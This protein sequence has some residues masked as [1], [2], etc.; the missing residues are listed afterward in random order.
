MSYKN[1]KS[2]TKKA[3][4]KDERTSIL[5]WILLGLT[6]LFLFWAPFQK[7]LF[8][9][10]TYDFERPLFS[11]FIWSA[12]ILFLVSL[13]QFYNWK[14]SSQRDL[15]SIVIWLIP[16][17]YVISLSSSASS[18]YAQ[19]GIYIQL[20]YV[21]FF[22][23]G[24]YINR[25]ES[26]TNLL[27]RFFVA[28][29][30]FVVLFGLFNWLGNK[31]IIFNMVSWFTNGMDGFGF[32][33]DAVMTDA[34][35]FRLTS[36]FQYANSYAAYLIAILFCCIYL[37]ISSKKL[38]PTLVHGMMAVP[39]IISFFLTLSR[40]GLV[41]LPIVLLVILPFLKPYKQVLYLVH[42]IISFVISL[43]ILNKVTSLGIEVNK[44]SIPNISYL[45]WGIL[46]A[47][48]LINGVI[49]VAIQKCEPFVEKKLSNI[50][51]YRVSNIFIPAVAIIIGALGVLLLL[52][53]TGLTQLLP[54]NIKN[55]IESINFQQHSVLE[56]GTFYVDA[57]KLYKDYP[58]IGAG[59]GA[60]AAL[61]EKYQNNPYVSRQA[62]N[63]FLQYL[64]EVG[65]LGFLI[66]L[67]VIG[68]VLY[69]FIRHSIKSQSAASDD[70]RFM[71]YIV[72]ISLL[73]HSMIDF[74]LSYVYLGALLFLSLGGM[75]S[76]SEQPALSEKW[77]AF[78]KYKW[79]YPSVLVVLS[80][81][82]FFSSTKMLTANSN[83]QSALSLA[84]SS[85]TIN[86][87]F[88]PLDNALKQHPNHPDY[89]SYKIDLLLQAYNQTKDEKLFNQ[90]TDMIQKTR[91]KE[92]HNRA[93]IDKEIYTLAIK[94][95]LPKALELVNNEINNFPWDIT[96]YEKNI[97]M[98]Y[99]LGTRSQSDKALAEKYWSQAMET[100]NTMVNKSKELELLPKGQQQGRPFGLTK[101]M[102]FTLGQI[103]FMHGKYASAESFLKFQLN[104]Q[105]N[106]QV[107]VEMARWYL[108]SLQKQNKNDES[109]YNKLITKDP[110]EKDEI[111]TLLNAT[112]SVK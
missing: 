77:L 76:G 8:N 58:I 53:G 43:V 52:Y 19:N 111:N 66:L 13:F 69:L 12:I 82:M 68:W 21:V 62:H 56:R 6:V 20:L 107:D 35:G 84:Q 54:E 40:G 18:Y 73:V 75:I 29:S 97:L 5:F 51:K 27:R 25:S 9:G 100:Y 24:L 11:S 34:N 10:N 3:M 41:I 64:V 17:S 92:P 16:I 49:S 36:I 93:L 28:S 72:T 37:I 71:F 101:N 86:E 23:V 110:K 50:S 67:F 39:I 46:L 96:L 78:N 98:N 90:A 94:D 14:L 89:A 102:A 48:S 38:I 108:A 105:F 30:Y 74:D 83:F 7:G 57:I 33:K 15:I 87:V 99:D 106:E 31:A 104:D 22:L 80:I 103:E 60:W 4:A 65:A 79:I 63:F 81:F 70:K 32:Y 88:I 109:L 1:P 26:G 47:A 95:Q 55:R 59:G 42:C 61:Y 91:A 2:S 85:K 112:F 45:G 44:E